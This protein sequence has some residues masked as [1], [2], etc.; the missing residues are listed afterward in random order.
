MARHVCPWWIGYLLLSPVRRWGQHPSKVF[1]PFVERGMTVV[2]VGCA[3]GFF[4]IDLARQVG[5]EGRVVAVDLQPRMIRTLERRAR[6]RGLGH[7]IE[8]RVCSEE[9][10]GIEDLA[11]AVD[12][13][14]AFAV[15]HEVPGEA[16]FMRQL[17]AVLRPTGRLLVAEPAGHVTAE[18]FDTSLAAAAV[19]GFEIISRPK[20]RRSHAAL[21]APVERGEV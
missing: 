12:F 9:S 3:M 14:L 20:I 21:L 7:R 2:D 6:R 18:A 8:A 1:G 15:V 5:E 16:D 11:A 4:T 13:A 10:L 19:A 17:R